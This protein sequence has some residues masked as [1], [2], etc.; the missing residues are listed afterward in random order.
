MQEIDE[1]VLNLEDISLR[2]TDAKYRDKGVR[3]TAAEVVD[4]LPIVSHAV[5]Q[6]KLAVERSGDPGGIARYFKV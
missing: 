4:L 5:G 6:M 2:M 1:H 3:L